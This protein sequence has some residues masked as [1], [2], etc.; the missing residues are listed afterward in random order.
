MERHT[1]K[2]R[3]ERETAYETF[4]RELHGV[5]SPQ[6]GNAARVHAFTNGKYRSSIGAA[7]PTF[8]EIVF[9]SADFVFGGR[10]EVED[11]LE[12]ALHAKNLGVVTGGGTGLGMCN[13]DVEVND[14]ERGLALIR[15]ALRE[16]GVAPST[17][18]YQGEPER[19]TLEVYFQGG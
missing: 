18:I 13:I 14:A 17:R 16:L 9:Q 2:S 3:Y 7:M 19:K 11:L 12:E 5:T 4:C 1:N 8:F 15:A 10:D 6:E